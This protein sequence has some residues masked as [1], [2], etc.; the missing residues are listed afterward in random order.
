MVVPLIHTLQISFLAL[1]FFTILLHTTISYTPLAK[2]LYHLLTTHLHFFL[3]FTL[4]TIISLYY[5]YHN[6][7]HRV[8]L[9]NYA[10]YK[11]PPHRKCTF[12]VCESFVLNNVHLVEKSID[13]MH[14]IYLKSGLG[15]ETYGPPFLFEGD[16]HNKNTSNALTL[17][18]ANQEAR[19][20]VV[21]SIDEL[22]AKTLI[23]PQSIDVVIVTCGAFSPSPSISSFIVNRYNLRPDVKTYNLSGMGCSAGILSVDFA[24][25]VLHGSRKVQNTLVVILENTTKNWYNGENRSMLVTNCIFRV[26]CAAAIM[27]TNPKLYKRAK[28]ELVHSLRTHHGADDSSYRAAFQEEDDKGISL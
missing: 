2:I 24:A 16:D 8:F 15:D 21:S 6:R 10:C 19:E 5:Y 18:N 1:L 26:G 17:K 13:F 7:P 25:R 11:P 20:G 28:M 12:K 9:L 22:L 23:E 3:L 4:C 27:S 14:K